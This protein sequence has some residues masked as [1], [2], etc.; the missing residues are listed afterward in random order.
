MSTSVKAVFF[1]S[2]LPL[3]YPLLALV[4]WVQFWVDKY[5]LLRVCRTPDQ[6][7]GART[8]TPTVA[9]VL[10]YCAILHCGFAVVAFA[11]YPMERSALADDA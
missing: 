9:G 8:L 4:L 11:L 7:Q 10:P 6:G 2:G 5:Q 1:S 3:L